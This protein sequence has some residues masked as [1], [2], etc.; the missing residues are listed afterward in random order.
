MAQHDYVIANDDGASVRADANAALAAIK[1]GNSHASTFPA[2]AVQGMPF[3]QNLSA[4]QQL[5]WKY[6]GAA[7]RLLS[8]V[9]PTNGKVYHTNVRAISGLTLSNNGTDATNDIDIAAGWTAADSDGHPLILTAA[10]TKQLDVAWAVGTNQGG[11]DTG[12]VGNNTYHV[13]MI[14]RPDTGVVDVLFSLS[15]SAP[16]MPTNY[17]QK[18]RVG[19]IIRE[20]AAIITFSQNG[21]EF[22]RLALATSVNAN[23]PGTSAVLGTMA[24]PTGVKVDAIFS[25]HFNDDAT[26]Y[27]LVTSPD[28]T[29]V[30]ADSTHLTAVVSVGGIRATGHLTIRT[31]T[32]AQVRYRVNV[33]DAGVFV[34]FFTVGWRDRRGQGD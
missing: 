3:T 32:S 9:D 6:D 28:Q 13:W 11:L 16:T 25:F 29:D 34:Q 20:S 4:T 24:V 12:A 2:G 15:A 10:I 7:W 18:R 23:N 1:S 26:N 5:E 27:L 33:S 30:A 14:R 31:N 17:T 22:L 19:S 8:I 21:D